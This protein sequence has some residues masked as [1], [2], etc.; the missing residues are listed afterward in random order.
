MR[1]C[2]TG[3]ESYYHLIDEVKC[4]FLRDFDATVAKLMQTI[5]NTG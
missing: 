3:R 5:A 2:T 4:Q 1:V